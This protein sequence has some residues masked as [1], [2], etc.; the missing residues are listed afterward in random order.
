VN[1]DEHDCVK[2]GNSSPNLTVIFC[3]VKEHPDDGP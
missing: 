3:D 1:P 2:N